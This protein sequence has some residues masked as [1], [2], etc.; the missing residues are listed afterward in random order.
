MLI[1][2]DFI[3]ER[4]HDRLRTDLIESVVRKA[5]RFSL[6]LRRQFST[7]IVRIP[8]RQS[9]NDKSGDS[10]K[11][12]PTLPQQHEGVRTW[13]GTMEQE[14]IAV[15]I[16]PALV[17]CTTKKGQEI[18]E[19]VEPLVE[20]ETVRLPIVSQKPVRVDSSGCSRP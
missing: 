3:N 12:L 15:F 4:H 18:T 10:S 19:T 11:P 17:R 8:E 20:A 13:S 9:G 2:G 1:F 6:I 7:I 5:I 14:E 16:R